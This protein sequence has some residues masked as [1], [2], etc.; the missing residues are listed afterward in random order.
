MLPSQL[1]EISK[2]RLDNAKKLLSTSQTLIDVGDYKSSA[3]RSY[4]AIFNAMRACLALHSIDYKRHS[5]II[6]DFRLHYIKTEKLE[7]KLSDIITAL[8]EMRNQSD[9]NDFYV[10]SKADV[11][12]QLSNATFF[13]EE[14][15][16]LLAKRWRDEI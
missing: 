8:F 15:E 10:V 2:L 12:Q 7:T 9:Y 3:N 4:Y 11:T 6:A 1:I 5:G 13:I 14:V 16:T